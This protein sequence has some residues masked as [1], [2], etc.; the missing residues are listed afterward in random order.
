VTKTIVVS[1]DGSE[2]CLKGVRHAAELAKQL[3][4]K[5]ELAYVSPPV[6]LPPSVYA[7]TIHR[8]EEAEDTHAK[9]VLDAAS[10]AAGIECVRV[11]LRGPPAE[12]ISDYVKGDDRFW[13]VVIGAKGHNALSRVMLG[14][15]TDRLVHICPKPVLVIR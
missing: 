10:R 14:S 7:E 8:I 11:H 2:A 15:V 5:L 6:L 3:S 12:A 1:V 13:G 4:A 9:D